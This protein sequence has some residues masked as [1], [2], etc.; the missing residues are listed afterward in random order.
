MSLRSSRSR[1]FARMGALAT[2]ALILAGCASDTELDTR[3][4]LQGPE[5]QAIEG[6]LSPLLWITYVVFAIILGLTVYSWWKHG[7]EGDDYQDDDWPEQVHGNNA[8]ELA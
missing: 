7:I 2:G 4:D 3:T 6:F 8:A 5:A 1:A